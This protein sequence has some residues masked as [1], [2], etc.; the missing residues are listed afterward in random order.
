MVNPG[1]THTV[2]PGEGALLGAN[3]LS[4]VANPV[5]ALANLNGLPMI[6]ASGDTTGATDTAALQAALTA[7]RIAGGGTVRG[8]PGSTYYITASATPITNSATLAT[9]TIYASL[10]IGSN[11]T[12]DMTDC[13]VTLVN[14]TGASPIVNYSLVSGSVAN[15][16][17]MTSG[18]NTCVTSLAAT[19]TVGQSLTVAG[20]GAAGLVPICGAIHAINT[21]TNTI[22]VVQIDGSGGTGIG[23]LAASNTVS[24]ANVCTWTRDTNVRIIGG[25]WNFGTNTDAADDLYC[26]KFLL[27]HLD[28]YTVDLQGV[29]ASAKGFI[30]CVGDATDGRGNVRGANTTAINTDIWHVTG[31]H[32]G[33]YIDELTGVSG[34]DAFSVSG[35]IKPTMSDISGNVVG[36]KINKIDMQSNLGWCTLIAGAGNLIDDVE[37]G[38][39]RGS[40]NGTNQ[41]VWVGD[42]SVWTAMVG[43]TYGYIDLGVI[44]GR[45]VNAPCIVGLISPA[46]KKIKAAFDWGMY[47]TSGVN[48][49]LT[50]ACQITGASTVTIDTLDLTGV[51]NAQYSGAATSV[52]N[53]SVAN[54]TVNQVNLREVDLTG[55]TTGCNMV[56]VNAA[57]TIGQINLVN[58]NSPATNGK[59]ISVTNASAVVTA[60]TVSGCNFGNTTV[61][62]SISTTTTS[63][64]Q[65]GATPPTAD[66]FGWLGWTC[67][68][69]NAYPTGFTPTLSKLILVRFRAAKTGIAGHICYD[70]TNG[71]SVLTANENYVGI[72]DTGQSTAG[73]ATLLGYSADQSG[74]WTTAGTYSTALTAQA[75]NSLD[76][77]AGQDYFAAFVCNGT[78]APTVAKS[79]GLAGLLNQGLSGLGL[80]I[81]VDFNSITGSL[82]TSITAANVV[83]SAGNATP[84]LFMVG[85]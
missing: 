40:A 49:A 63:V 29:T 75:A 59:I 67:D 12:L 48:Y 4:D 60:V 73:Q 44:A 39:V 78:T 1:H 74:V 27:R 84:L 68:P 52:L 85:V 46:A 25:Y 65:L 77:V 5:T 70:V 56:L 35:S 16:G 53:A 17:A 43:G 41:G 83:T 19:A 9:T 31:P 79:G 13:T 71:G 38:V 22:T 10:I 14:G 62:S 11:T 30:V 66:S 33:L 37:V 76:L 69:N 2:T 36:I 55:N 7:A 34:D 18:A 26:A 42:D 23:T 3:N 20:A 58:C 21:G 57:C 45:I 6:R 54:V 82:P 80:R 32:Y 8:N 50:A 64:A 47:S 28:H 15:D 61:M 72:Y 51:V 81:A 24:S